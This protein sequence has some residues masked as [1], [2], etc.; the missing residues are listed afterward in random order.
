MNIKCMLIFLT[1]MTTQCFAQKSHITLEGIETVCKA[2]ER[3]SIDA[4]IFLASRTNNFEDLTL[5]NVRA[6][7]MMS[8]NLAKE[9]INK[10]TTNIETSDIF[11]DIAS[12]TFKYALCEKLKRPKAD[13]TTI[14]SENY[15]FCRKTLSGGGERRPLPCF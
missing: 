7:Y 9:K 13:A 14:A 4:L 1:F 5:E 2:S 3:D 10:I 12:D 11:L 6:S 15:F 8:M